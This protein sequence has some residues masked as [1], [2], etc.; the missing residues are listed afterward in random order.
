[1]SQKGVQKVDMTLN[2]WAEALVLHD[3]TAAASQNP[4]TGVN[5]VRYSVYG[6]WR[7]YIKK[8]VLGVC[9]CYYASTSP[10]LFAWVATIFSF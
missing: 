1:M 2:A 7:R 4:W 5:A 9:W 8:I 3:K 10:G 6:G